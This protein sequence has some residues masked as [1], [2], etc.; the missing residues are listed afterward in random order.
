MASCIEKS[1]KDIMAGTDTE[2]ENAKFQATVIS[3]VSESRFT[4]TDGDAQIY[5]EFDPKV[6]KRHIQ[7]LEEGCSFT[8]F[9]LQVMSADT[10]VFTK[11]SYKK[12]AV[13]VNVQNTAVVDLSGLIG[14]ANKQL[15]QKALYV[16]VWEIGVE[17]GPYKNGAVLQKIKVGDKQFTV[18]MS[19]WNEAV[20]ISNNLKVGSVIRIKNFRMDSFSKKCADEP[21]DL[22]FNGRTPRTVVEVVSS[23]EVPPALR[24]LS[25]NILKIETTGVVDDVLDIYQYKSCPGRLD[26]KCGKSI[27]EDVVF[28]PKCKGKITPEILN[29]DFI[30]TVV[31]FD[32]SGDI[33]EMKAFKKTLTAFVV[34]NMSLEEGLKSSLVGKH[35][36]ALGTKSTDSEN[37]DRMDEIKID[38]VPEHKVSV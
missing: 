3:K 7:N 24:S 21:M 30:C 23:K 1:I 11:G 14:V 15:V 28:C 17:Q 2:A 4:V 25:S 36:T 6:P 13:S 34:D 31:I 29:E 5:V 33:F 20:K 19:F 9:K 37:L 16:K 10:L 8:F 22:S 27:K 26:T 35:V 18:A 32:D 38:Y 12:E